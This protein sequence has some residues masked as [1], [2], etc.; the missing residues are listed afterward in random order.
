M[1]TLIAIIIFT[2]GLPLGLMYA[3][4]H[5]TTR[6]PV[7]AGMVQ[8]WMAAH[9]IFEADAALIEHGLEPVTAVIDDMIGV[10]KEHET[11]ARAQAAGARRDEAT[12]CLIQILPP[13]LH[14]DACGC[15]WF[16][17]GYWSPCHSH[18]PAF[19][20]PVEQWASEMS[21]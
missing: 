4:R 7:P 5:A 19:E 14:Q 9:A 3:V 1:L 8:E 15:L 12:E 21:E 6:P 18:D 13:R 2:A 17:E 20:P 16:A 11:R 10:V